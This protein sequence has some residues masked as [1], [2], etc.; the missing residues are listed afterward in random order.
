MSSLFGIFKLDGRTPDPCALEAMRKA[1][2]Y[3]TP[4]KEGS[5]SEGPVA[6]GHCMLW[7][8]PES[9]LENQPTVSSG[10]EYIT[11]IT[12]DARLDNRAE[13]ADRFGLDSIDLAQTTDVDLLMM[14]WKKWGESCPEHL[15][16]DFAFVIWDSRNQS[17]FCVR[18][19]V[20]IR[21]FYYFLT[22]KM[23]AF[24][25]DIR[26]LVALQDV[27]RELDPEA[28]SIF[29]TLGGLWSS[30]LTFL[31]ALKK[32]PPASC[33]SLRGDEVKQRTYWCPEDAPALNFASVQA[34]A[35]QLRK[36]LERVVTDRL[37]TRFPLTSHLSGG[38]DS[39]SI[40][41]IAARQ[42]AQKGERLQ[43]FN[44]VPPPRPDDDPGHYEWANARQM[45]EQEGIDLHN[46]SLSVPDIYHDLKTTDIALGCNE[47]FFYESSIQNAVQKNGGRV[48]L[49]GWGGDELIT[50]HGYAVHADLF[51]H[52]QVWKAT[53]DIYR[54]SR[55]CERPL[56]R[57]LA[58]FARQIFKPVL[59]AWLRNQFGGG[60]NDSPNFA[61]CTQPEFRA[62]MKKQKIEGYRQPGRSN[63]ETQL[64][65]LKNGHIQN[66][67]ECWNSMAMERRLEYR[68]PLLDKRIIEF[69]LGLPPEYF[70]Q[71]GYG[72]YIFREAC[73]GLMSEE[74]RM[75]NIKIE[76][77]RVERIIA[78][79]NEA[80]DEI[81]TDLRKAKIA[82][83]NNLNEQFVSIDCIL[84]QYEQAKAEPESGVSDALDTMEMLLKN[85]R[86]LQLGAK[87]G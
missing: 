64:S 37:R 6:L 10:T 4:D 34:C 33:L 61:K 62:F 39:S 47:D 72:R 73:K 52:G 69:S 24:A 86:V 78:E 2:A 32:L 60:T 77:R 11:V 75:Q 31:K 20:G 58:L 36:L 1:H 81:S 67:V 53:M 16:G 66:R 56:T 45:A 83:Q 35:S 48:I 8:T 57:F 38:L 22:D 27:S 44:W 21:P 49:S 42:L 9:L 68:Y 41:A 85:I 87:I 63:R 23:F 43:S 55:A 18:D 29:L 5:W 12:A 82:G 25:S 28:V 76:P 70:R 59:P 74:V 15:L 79:V 51:W 19:H 26:V 46:V 65:L 40:S 84:A 50:H 54:V 3:W 13:L 30:E 7:N 71:K 17:L 14:A 80:I